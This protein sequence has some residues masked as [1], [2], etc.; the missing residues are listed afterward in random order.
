MSAIASDE[1][2]P[3]SPDEEDDGYSEYD[4]EAKYVDDVITK[5]NSLHH[6][7]VVLRTDDISTSPSMN[8]WMMAQPDI[9]GLISV[10]QPPGESELHTHGDASDVSSTADKTPP[11]PLTERRISPLSDDTSSSG[12]DSDLPNLGGDGSTM[13][14][15]PLGPSKADL[16]RTFVSLAPPGAHLERAHRCM[17]MNPRTWI[18]DNVANVNLPTGSHIAQCMNDFIWHQGMTHSDTDQGMLAHPSDK[19]T[20]ASETSSL[21]PEV[22]LVSIRLRPPIAMTS[23][24]KTGGL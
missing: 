18:H 8:A 12:S 10:W 5:F 13:G 7:A 16:N 19:D 24:T 17:A 6:Q 14:F 11:P 9:T 4:V 21:D 2:A 22:R 3:E 1:T 23:T 20:V 15:M